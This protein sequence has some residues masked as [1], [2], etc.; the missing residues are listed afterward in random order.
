MSRFAGH[1]RRSAKNRHALSLKTDHPM[2]AG[3]PTNS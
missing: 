2:E 1:P 3:Q